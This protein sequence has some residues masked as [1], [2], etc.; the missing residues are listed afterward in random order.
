MP[1]PASR[2]T[3]RG[4][5]HEASWSRNHVDAQANPAEPVPIYAFDERDDVAKHVGQGED[6]AHH[7]HGPGHGAD[8]VR[9]DRTVADANQPVIEVAD[10]ECHVGGRNLARRYDGDLANAGRGCGGAIHGNLIGEQS[11]TGAVRFGAVQNA[12]ILPTRLATGGG[13]ALSK[14]GDQALN[15]TVFFPSDYPIPNNE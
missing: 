4:K 9:R 5:L 11:L 1:P 13:I 14:D 3:A 12:W 10:T 2:P 6:I 8:A 15:L 7:R